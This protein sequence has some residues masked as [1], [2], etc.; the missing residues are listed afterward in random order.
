MEPHCE[1]ELMSVDAILL[2]TVVHTCPGRRKLLQL[3]LDVPHALAIAALAEVAHGFEQR[4]EYVCLVCRQPGL[5]P[6]GVYLYSTRLLFAYQT[7]L[8][9]LFP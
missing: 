5:E 3:W 9:L 7:N 6:G 1:A 8:Y 2:S 4:L